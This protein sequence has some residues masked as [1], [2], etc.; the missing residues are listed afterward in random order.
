MADIYKVAG[1]ADYYSK[2][3]NSL[4]PTID[5]VHS[6]IS[7]LN[8]EAVNNYINQLNKSYNG[9]VK[10]MEDST[11]QGIA[12]LDQQ[13]QG[14]YDRNEINRLI[15]QRQT[16]AALQRMGLGKSGLNATQQAGFAI[17]QNNADAAASQQK[18]AAANNLRSLLQQY[19]V[20]LEQSR[21]QNEANARYDTAQRNSS[22]YT[23][24][25]GNAMNMAGTFAS[26][27]ASDI[28]SMRSQGATQAYNTAAS[29]SKTSKSASGSSASGMSTG[30]KDT[31]KGVETLAQTSNNSDDLDN[32]LSKRVLLGY[33]T[34]EEANNIAYVYLDDFPE[35]SPKP[36]L[37]NS[38]NE[39][40][41][42]T[43]KDGKKVL[44]SIKR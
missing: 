29:K 35:D 5:A 23:D 31:V 21:L 16:D 9:S 4:V 30:Y 17:A 41:Y 1:A 43:G 44:R 38:S 11:N 39:N 25:Y 15:G 6:K 37:Y 8:N 10:Y 28:N 26:Q 2:N 19:K 32:Y 24:L 33:I 40:R 12:A 14:V 3:L 18:N 42:Y 13:Y 36:V 34:E 20:N 22:T 27:N 7:G